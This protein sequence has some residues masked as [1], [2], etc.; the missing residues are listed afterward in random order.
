MPWTP[1]R[2]QR[3]HSEPMSKLETRLMGQGSSSSASCTKPAT[4]THVVWCS[5]VAPRY[6]NKDDGCE[7]DGFRI[8][9]PG[10]VRAC[11]LPTE[12]SHRLCNCAVVS[13]L[14]ATDAPQKDF[15]GRLL[16]ISNRPRIVSSP[17]HAHC[18]TS[19]DQG[20]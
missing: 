17:C 15:C 14:M 11:W 5:S 9:V 13:Y 20:I 6:P 10:T 7:G 1:N 12:W 16:Q 2:D 19:L 18:D 8:L 3:P 4:R